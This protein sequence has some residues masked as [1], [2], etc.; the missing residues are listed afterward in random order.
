MREEWVRFLSFYGIVEVERGITRGDTF[1]R[2]SIEGP[3][4]VSKS[5][6]RIA[7]P[8]RVVVKDPAGNDQSG[9]S[10]PKETAEKF[11]VLGIP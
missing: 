10:I 6:K 1:W 5:K 2:E 9:L 7:N 8:K 3:F 11:L 4:I